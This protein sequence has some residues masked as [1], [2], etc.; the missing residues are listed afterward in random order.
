MCYWVGTRKV[1]EELLRRYSKGPQDEIAQLFYDT[2]NIK[3]HIELQEHYVAIGKGKPKLTT[4]VNEN[5]LQFRNMQWT[6]P[7]TYFDK[8]TNKDITRELLNST[9]ERVFYQHKDVIFN[10]RCI[11]PIDGYYEYYHQGKETFPYFIYPKDGGILYAGGIW[12]QQVNQESGEI[13]ELFSIITTP[14]NELTA[15]IHNNPDAPNG[16]R[17]LLLLPEDVIFDYLNPKLT[18]EEL[19]KILIP[20][21][22]NVLKAH[23][24]IRFQR[25][26]NTQFV[27]T[28]KVQEYFE[29]PELLV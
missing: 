18:T 24:V 8:K 2:F 20:H 26:E 10:Q 9:C 17:M 15:K 1:R 27:N 25:K 11:V 29:Y 23:P 3:N 13:K 16:S 12:T 4:L 6:L 14:P 22:A 19:K 28:G 7:Y 21:D 5:G